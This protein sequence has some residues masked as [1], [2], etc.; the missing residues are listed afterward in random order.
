MDA[1]AFTDA[2]KR[3]REVFTIAEGIGFSFKLLDIGGGFPGVDDYD[4]RT[5]D[6]NK[7]SEK[8]YISFDEIADAINS[9]LQ[10]SF[11]DIEDLRVI[12]EPGRFFGTSAMILITGVTSKKSINVKK[13]DGTTERIFHYY[14]N[15]SLYGMFNNVIFDKAHVEFKLLNRYK[16]KAYKTVIF[17]ETCDSA[18]KIIE[19]IELPELACGD[20]LYVE[21]HG[22][23]TWASASEFNG[24]CKPM[25]YPIFT[26]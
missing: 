12:A 25:V 3:A 23:Y 18:D 6:E 8:K 1:S 20:Y 21:N 15:S 13:P 19:G 4:E 7:I 16:S 11:S 26:Y 14:I 22:A 24:F 17:G 9:E 2:I 10:Q 5:Q